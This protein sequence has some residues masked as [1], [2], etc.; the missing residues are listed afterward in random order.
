MKL[1]VAQKIL[2]EHR[3]GT[4]RAN[5]AFIPLKIDQVLTQDATGTM[6]YLQF[7]A[8]GLPRIQIPLAVSYVDHNILQVDSRNPDDHRFLQTAAAKYGAYFS[9]PGN[10]ICHQLHLEN[11]ARPGAVLLGSDSHTPTCGGMGMIALGCGGLD[12]AAAMAGVPYE[13]P[14]PKIRQIRLTGR[15][16]RPWVT[17]MDVSLELL[18]RLTVRGGVGWIHEFQGPGIGNLS[19]SERATICNLGAELGATTSLFPSDEVTRHFLRI[20]GRE[21]EWQELL[22][23][24][25]SAGDDRLVLDLSR[26]EPLVAQ[27]FSPDRVAP[28]KDLIGLKVD[29]VCIGSCSNSSY[30]L[31][32][33]VARLLKGRQLAPRLNLLIN[34]GSRQVLRS[35][36]P[37]GALDDLIAAGAR[38]LEA[39]CGPCIGMG[40]AP[41][42]QGVSFRSYNRNFKGRSGTINAQVYLANPLVG[43][44]IALKGEVVDPFRTPF[45][46]P[47]SSWKPPYKGLDPLIESPALP[48][49]GPEILRGP[50]IKPIPRGKPLAEDFQASV[51]IKLG[52]HVTTDDILPG[53][54]EVLPFR[55]NI[56][57]IS[58]YTFSR[59]DSTFAERA[60]EAR[61]GVILGG[62]NYGQGSSREHAALAPMYLGIRAVLA[63]SFARIHLNNLINYGI[64]PLV[65]ENSEDYLRLKQGDLLTFSEVR[66]SI[67]KLKPVE[68]RRGNEEKIIRLRPQ[69]TANKVE[70]LLAGGLLPY[71]RRK[72]RMTIK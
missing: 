24:P 47:R 5:E 70:V 71:L 49:T 59:L 52:D 7:E 32:N 41:P 48:G 12:I 34:P 3:A 58:R 2:R 15:L 44:L 11:F 54:S 57:A 1:T 62:E 35:L 26:V 51:L 63:K 18:R 8:I 64:L 60:L 28:L 45:M 66:K 69:I 17:A 25:D 38:I 23:D 61:G 56:P 29:Q 68:V 6:V 36:S 33:A 19:I 42:D 14:R 39:G 37:V 13:L 9:P 20:R 27:P 46:L 53:G 21:K 30:E 43:A 67:R 40:G 31:L 50:N 55:S 10:G 16:R 22:P 4:A 65:F 72:I